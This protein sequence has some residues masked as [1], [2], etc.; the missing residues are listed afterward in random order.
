[1]KAVLYILIIMLT[2]AIVN[3][4]VRKKNNKKNDEDNSEE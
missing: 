3:Y 4:A 1:M 2:L